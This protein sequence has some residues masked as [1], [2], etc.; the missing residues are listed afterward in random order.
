MVRRGQG[1]DSLNATSSDQPGQCVR[2]MAIKVVPGPVVS[3]RGARVGVPRGIL[4]VTKA[5]TCI[6]T[7][8]HGS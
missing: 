1:T 4:H 8:W 5:R 2:R 3:S 7:E 6:E